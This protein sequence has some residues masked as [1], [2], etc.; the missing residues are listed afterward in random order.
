MM[1]LGGARFLTSEVPPVRLWSWRGARVLD[2][3]TPRETVIT[4]N[5][6][7]MYALPAEAVSEQDPESPSVRPKGLHK[8]PTGLARS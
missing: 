7:A 1:V 2:F 3:Q 4:T 8:G 6:A 5:T